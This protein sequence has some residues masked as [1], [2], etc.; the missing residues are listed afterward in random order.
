MEL[1]KRRRL[2]VTAGLL[3][4]MALGALEATVVGT[5]MP[6]VIASLGGLNHYSWVFSAYLLTA[7]ASVP[8]WGRLADLYGRRRLYLIGVGMFL[9]GSALSGAAQSMAQ[10]IAFRALQG[11]G[12]G[13][14][15]PL[16]MTIIGEIYT[17]QERPRVQAVSSGMW[18]VASIAGP[19]AGGWITDALSWRWVFFLNLPAGLLGAVI[20][21]T[22]YREPRERREV[23]VDWLGTGLLFAA[24]T[25]LLVGLSVST[26]PW[27]WLALAAALTVWLVHLERRVPDPILPVSLFAM[28]I[29]RWSLPMVFLQ[30]MGMFGALAFI[31]LLV[32]GGL[33][34]SA[35]EAGRALTPLFLGWVTT[36]I[37]G[38][39]LTLV[40]GYRPMAWLGTVLMSV[41]FAAL[42]VLDIG[43]SRIALV[44]PS[45]ALGAGMG[46]SGLALLL[47][48]QHGVPRSD[49]GVAT[50]FNQFSRSI[51]AAIGVALMG[52]A[53][54]LLMGRSADSM[55]AEMAGEGLRLD[56]D[57]AAQL[58]SALQAVFGLASGASMLA[59][60]PAL[61]LP[62]IAFSEPVPARVAEQ[63]LA[64]E[65]TTLEPRDE[66]SSRRDQS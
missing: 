29:V 15:V 3:L 41:A 54:A 18:G 22:T 32:Q 65:M 9:A 52:S 36:A 62:R 1:S 35:T 37:A 10:L 23:T 4:G 59:M 14:L 40:F 42:A 7:T 56:R 44:A 25:S 53:L 31:P 55:Q 6:T 16:S 45:F 51:G 48:T 39:R 12:A 19:L 46:F 63:L 28:P 30:G 27:P 49:L 47:A 17:I 8:I 33:G 43:A 13:A 5:A 58:V 50:S 64:A 21:S 24:A 57:S 11:L 20:F 26:V 34:G 60:L 2:A 61:R 66:P 38:A